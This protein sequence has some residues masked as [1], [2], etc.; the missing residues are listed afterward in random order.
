MRSTTAMSWLMKRKDEPE[1]RLQLHHQVQDLRLHR[2][3][4]RR[5]RLVGDD[6]LRVRRRAPGRWRPA[7]AGRRTIRAGS[8]AGSCA[9]APRGRTAPPP[10]PSSSTA[11]MRAPKFMQRLCHL[12]AQPSVGIER[13][14]GVLEDHLHVAARPPQVARVQF[15]AR[16]CRRARSAPD[17]RLRPAAGSSGRRSTCRS[18]I[19]RPA[20]GSRHLR[21][22]S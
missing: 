2:D 6:E 16:P 15:A 22:R 4:E 21:A 1:V 13:G 8:A 5:N 12:I 7:G 9:A 14:E 17:V 18:R 20:T 11:A 10:G 19:R 3:V